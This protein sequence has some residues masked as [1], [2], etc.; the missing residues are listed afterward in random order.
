MRVSVYQVRLH[1]TDQFQKRDNIFSIDLFQSL[2]KPIILSCPCLIL[3]QYATDGRSICLH[4]HYI[5]FSHTDFRDAS[6]RQHL[7][8]SAINLKYVVLIVRDLPWDERRSFQMTSLGRFMTLYDTILLID[9]FI[10]PNV[11]SSSYLV[12]SV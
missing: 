2:C 7:N 1:K 4:P 6:I 9:P 11:Y 12:Q 10:L 3:Y 8:S 5:R